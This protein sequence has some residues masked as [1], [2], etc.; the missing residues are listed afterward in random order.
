MRKYYYCEA[1]MGIYTEAEKLNSKIS[2]GRFLPIGEYRS[3]TQATAAFEEQYP[4]ADVAL[5]KRYW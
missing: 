4:M 3:R 1:N 5:L 2:A